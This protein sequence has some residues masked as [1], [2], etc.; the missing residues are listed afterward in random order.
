MCLYSLPRSYATQKGYLVIVQEALQFY[1]L[2]WGSKV[3]YKLF[4]KIMTLNPLQT[5]TLILCTDV[6]EFST[7]GRTKNTP[8]IPAFS[9]VT[10]LFYILCQS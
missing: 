4:K 10:H 8:T 3:S 7:A 2:L 9:L 6:S 5:H 1:K